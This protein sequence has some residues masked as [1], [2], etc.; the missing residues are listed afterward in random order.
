M[1]F[2]KKKLFFVFIEEVPPNCTA[3]IKTIITINKTATT[4]IP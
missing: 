4:V 2:A 3:I 1:H